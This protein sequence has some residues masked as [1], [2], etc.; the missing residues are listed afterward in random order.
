[1]EFANSIFGL[2]KNSKSMGVKCKKSITFYN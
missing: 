1:V 2:Q